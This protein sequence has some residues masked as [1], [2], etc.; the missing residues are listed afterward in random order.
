MAVSESSPGSVRQQELPSPVC[1]LPLP[2]Q[3][4]ASVSPATSSTASAPRL[5]TL[6]PATSVEGDRTNGNKQLPALTNL[7]AA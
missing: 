7:Q 6:L 5:A 4:T 2:E 3:V 1:T